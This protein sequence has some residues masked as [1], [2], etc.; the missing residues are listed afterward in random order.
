MGEVGLIASS[1]PSSMAIWM[2]MMGCRPAQFRKRRISLM[3]FRRVVIEFDFTVDLFS[4]PPYSS[5]EERRARSLPVGETGDGD[6]GEDGG[7]GEEDE[8]CELVSM[9]L[10]DSR[11][12]L[13]SSVMSWFMVSRL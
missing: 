3:A 8:E 7:G 12:K 13:P 1:S 11:T 5:V 10:A 2:G 6:G 9:S 4:T